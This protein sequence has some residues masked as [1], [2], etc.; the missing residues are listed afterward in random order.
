MSSSDL[1]EE[2]REQ[3]LKVIE[4]KK[5]TFREVV[6]QTSPYSLE[7][8]VENAQGSLLFDTLGRPYIDFTSGIGVMNLGHGNE[9]VNNAI[10]E[11]L[12]YYSH[13][14]VYGEH[15]QRMQIEFCD[16]IVNRFV[17]FEEPNP[18]LQVFPVNSGNEAVDLAL[19]MVRKLTKK[20]PMLAIKKGF[21][22]RGYGAM[23]VT[24]NQ[25]YKQD[26]FVDDESTVWLD[27]DIPLDKNSL[28][29]KRYGGVI[30]ELVQG[31]AG[32]IPLKQEWAENLVNLAK[33]HGLLVVIDEVQTGF[34]RTG[35]FLA[36][37]RYGVK[38]D[39]T[40]L[41][42]AGGGGLPFGAVVAQKDLFNDLQ[43]PPLSHLSTFGGN[44]VVMA[45]GLATIEQIDGTLLRHVRDMGQLLAQ[46]VQGLARQFPNVVAGSQG[47]G[48]MRGLNLVDPTLT[49]DF[50]TG[51][52]DNGL[53]L[54]FKLN[55]GATLRMSPPLNIS[56]DEII[57]AVNIMWEV[58]SSLSED[59]KKA[60]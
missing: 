42:K 40:L 27:P 43:S 44:P 57:Q 24:W 38:A 60:E 1:Q 25:D 55:A 5:R 59:L 10:K 29:W 32:C 33:D 58:A 46:E 31:E 18:G 35:H 16:A 49:H 8:D 48:L 34:G 23:Q 2:A 15:I 54:H 17:S 20:K 56:R 51:C 28:D 26:F 11:Q 3:V 13:T 19:K 14:M 53:I 37:K 47:I 6:A 9:K 45:A 36:Q 39:I 4:E 7:F 41:G 21:H 52:R 22:G 50:Y 12:R 30:L